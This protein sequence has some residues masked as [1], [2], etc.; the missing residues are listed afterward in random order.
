ML[1]EERLQDAYLLSYS[2]DA[3]TARSSLA[4]VSIGSTICNIGIE[5]VS[6]DPVTGEF[7]FVKE[8][9]PQAVYETSLSFG[10]S[11]TV[12]S[13]FTPALGVLDLSDIQLLSTVSFAGAADA[14][15]MLILSQESGLLLEVDR[16]GTV[17]SLFDLSV[18]S[19]NVADLGIEGVTIDANGTIYPAAENGSSPTLYTL[20]PTAPVPLPAAAWLL[21]S[22][23]GGLGLLGKR[24]Q[25]V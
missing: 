21:L 5:G 12:S 6:Y 24:R 9:T 17:L 25:V 8:K 1:A 11:A 19:S 7:F 16:N 10:G 23:L 15:N 20:T 2:A 14:S 4:S 22:G 18:I 13:L 3:T